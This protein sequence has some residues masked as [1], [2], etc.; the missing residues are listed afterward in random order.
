MEKARPLTKEQ[1]AEET[2]PIFSKLFEV[3]EV[4][5][6]VFLP[7]FNNRTILF[8]S[9]FKLDSDELDALSKAIGEVGDN[10]FYLSMLERLDK[11]NHGHHQDWWIPLEDIGAYENLPGIWGV[12]E[13]ALYSPS[14]QWG[15]VCS[16]DEF[17]VIGGTDEFLDAFFRHS[18]RS[19]EEHLQ[20]FFEDMKY[21]KEKY[22]TYYDTLPKLLSIIFG[23][24]RASTLLS[25]YDLP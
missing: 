20:D 23:P 9:Y 24:E 8:P 4:N 22:G 25:E 14:G 11:P 5:I 3:Y 2:E 7:V 6:P 13:N 16:Q 15:L 17:G 12:L 21:Y 1:L 19:A 10:G 18:K